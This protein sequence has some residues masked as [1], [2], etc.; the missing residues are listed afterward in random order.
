MASVLSKDD[1]APFLESNFR[2][3]GIKTLFR[4]EVVLSTVWLATAVFIVGFFISHIYRENAERNFRDLLRAELYN[5]INSVT[6]GDQGVLVGSPQL[7]DLRFAKLATGWYWLVEPGGDYA[8][9]LVSSS[10]GTSSLPVVSKS[11]VPFDENYER[12]YGANDGFGNRVLVVETEVVLDTR[13]RSARFRVTGNTAVVE[14]DVRD[15]TLKLYLSLIGFGLSGLLLHA[16][17]RRS[18]RNP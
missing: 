13:G 5:V 9:P 4:R 2:W 18:G 16:L 8:A 14:D 10:V 15:F 1:A 12:Y 7:G 3:D 11:E 6:I 17:A